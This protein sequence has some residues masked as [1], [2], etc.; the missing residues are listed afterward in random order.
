MVTYEN[1]WI[2]IPLVT[3]AVSLLPFPSEFYYFFRFIIFCSTAFI[4]FTD[5]PFKLKIGTLYAIIIAIIFNPFFPLY[6]HSKAIWIIAD[7]FAAIF[8][9]LNLKPVN[10]KNVASD[11]TQ[12]N[13]NTNSSTKNKNLPL[14]ASKMFEDKSAMVESDINQILLQINILVGDK[15]WSKFIKEPYVIGFIFS[16]VEGVEDFY[17]EAFKWKSET[18]GVFRVSLFRSILNGKCQSLAELLIDKSVPIRKLVLDENFKLGAKHGT[19][20]S[21]SSYG[22]IPNVD[23]LVL[24]KVGVGE[25]NVAIKDAHQMAKSQKLDFSVAFLAVTLLGFAI[26]WKNEA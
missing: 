7:L 17:L 4:I 19:V 24:P 13:I 9:W 8:F 15:L 5:Q 20:F 2:F 23:A 11:K 25:T 14:D 26:K 21:A 12:E 16:W 22:E 3:L 10:D 1:R 18:R 6:F